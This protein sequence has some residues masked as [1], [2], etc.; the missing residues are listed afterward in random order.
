MFPGRGV[1]L[2]S[3]YDLKSWPKNTYGPYAIRVSA[4]KRAM[5]KIVL[6]NVLD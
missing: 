1:R 3:N 5:I 6:V 2:L 4:T